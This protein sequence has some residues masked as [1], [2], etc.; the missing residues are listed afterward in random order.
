LDF[1]FSHK[2]ASFNDY[3]S[4]HHIAVNFDTIKAVWSD[5]SSFPC[6]QPHRPSSMVLSFPCLK[7][8][9][10]IVVEARFCKNKDKKLL[11]EKARYRSYKL[12]HVLNRE[13]ARERERERD[14]TS[15]YVLLISN[16]S[17]YTRHM[18]VPALI[19]AHF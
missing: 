5:I 19:Q 18:D 1:H 6:L 17:I 11:H 2:V 16:I 10:F 8:S 4:N 9:H 12:L 7:F 14:A 13:R 15:H 3:F